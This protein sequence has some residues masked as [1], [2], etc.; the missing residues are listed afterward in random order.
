MLVRW[1]N[2][3]DARVIYPRMKVHTGSNPVLTTNQKIDRK[4]KKYEKL[5]RQKQIV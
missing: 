3:K 4:I 5:Y 1:R 2:W